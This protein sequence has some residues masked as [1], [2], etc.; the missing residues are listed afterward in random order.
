MPR[1]NLAQDAPPNRITI[2]G[3]EYR[4]NVD[5][6]VWIGVLQAL[7]AL[8]LNP[9][10]PEAILQDLETIQKIETDVFGKVIDAPVADVLAAIR[11][12]SMGYPEAPVGRGEGAQV[13]TYSFD[14][15]LNYI[16]LAIE[17]QFNEDLSY[18]R[19]EP[20]HWWLFLLYFR[21]LSGNHYILQLME[22]RGYRGKD[23]Q[24]RRQAR[25]FALPEENNARD[26]AGEAALKDI[27]Y[28]C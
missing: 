2:G 7:R 6:R 18:R 11:E 21:A 3:A 22:I 14:W 8:I 12:F 1:P 9:D 26:R 24:M 4:V 13:Q 25:R 10:M 19:K 16:I 28:G 17:N 20:F 5:Y 15:D 23:A 27:F